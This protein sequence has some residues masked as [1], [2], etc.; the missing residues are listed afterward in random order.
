MLQAEDTSTGSSPNLARAKLW[1][2]DCLTNHPLCTKVVA[3][4]HTKFHPRRVINICDPKKPF[5][6]ILS[7]TPIPY[8]ALSYAWGDGYRFL[9]LESNLAQHLIC[10]PLLKLPR[11][12]R[13]AIRV[14]AKLDISH[15]WIDALCIIQD[16]PADLEA[17]LPTMGDIYRHAVFTIY[18]EGS[19]STQSGLFRERDVKAYRPV[20]VEVVGLAPDGAKTRLTLATRWSGTD[21]LKQRSWCLQEEV[22]TS[23][24]LVFGAQMG[25]RC[26]TSSASETRPAPQARKTALTDVLAGDMERLRMWLY[27]AADMVNSPRQRWFRGNQFDAW[28]AVVEEYSGRQLRAVSDNIKALSGLAAM[29]SRTHG[30]RYL[31]GLWAEDL[32]IG[33]AWYVALNDDRPVGKEEGP[34]W[35][36]AAVGKVRLKFRTWEA[37]S[38]H[39]VEEGIEM[40]EKD[41]DVVDK[42]NPYGAVKAG[43]LTLRGRSWKGILVYDKGYR[44][45]RTRPV[46]KPGAVGFPGF[47]AEDKKE[48]PRYPAMLLDTKERAP[49]AEVGLDFDPA[50]NADLEGG[51]EVFCLLLHVQKSR[52]TRRYTFLIIERVAKTGTNDFDCRRLGL[53]WANESVRTRESGFFDKESVEEVLLD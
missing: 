22:L 30:T 51:R 13:D 8:V 14:A 35:S 10:I 20:E 19:S 36:W 43:R 6:Q 29:F 32:Q 49:V 46:P 27:A 50:R 53:G 25:W 39:V 12:F 28:Y 38:E 37:N 23:R 31:A 41:C 17:E 34:S 3:Q 52:E 5:L 11:T 45:Y 42:L 26:I 48:H 15:I 33:L 1:M 40:L 21:Y 7:D 47:D 4:Q 44:E 18:A 2:T 9:T 24:F 16:R